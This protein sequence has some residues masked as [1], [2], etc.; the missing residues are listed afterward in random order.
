MYIS[1]NKVIEIME[2]LDLGMGKRAGVMEDESV[3]EKLRAGGLNVVP[4]SVFLVSFLGIC[5]GF[6]GDIDYER[7]QM[8]P[9]RCKG[10]LLEVPLIEN[11]QSS[12]A[13]PFLGIPTT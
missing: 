3:K 4:R 10:G 9:V 5:R 7:Q 12:T 1:W 8:I 13:H 11:C 6:R 2:L